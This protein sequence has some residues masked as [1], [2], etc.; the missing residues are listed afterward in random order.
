M[1]GVCWGHCVLICVC[2]CVVYAYVLH[3]CEYVSAQAA[4]LYTGWSSTLGISLYP[5]LPYCFE[6]EKKSFYYQSTRK[7]EQLRE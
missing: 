3:S 5:S 6:T 2:V 4:H 7:E 1:D